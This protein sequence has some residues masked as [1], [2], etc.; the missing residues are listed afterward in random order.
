MNLESFIAELAGNGVL[1]IVLA[2]MLYNN[3]ELVNRLFQL[4]ENN[5]AVMTKLTEEISELKDA[6]K[7][8]RE[9]FGA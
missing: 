6:Q 1:G 8:R 2:W 4:V 5:T 3:R 9:D 7:R